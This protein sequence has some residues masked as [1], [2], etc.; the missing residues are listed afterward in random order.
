MIFIGTIYIAKY[1]FWFLK[2]KEDHGDHPE[3]QRDPPQE[4]LTERSESDQAQTCCHHD[5]LYLSIEA[6]HFDETAQSRTAPEFF[7]MLNSKMAT[8]LAHS[9]QGKSGLSKQFIWTVALAIDV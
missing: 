8:A 7:G 4:G 5:E 2:E 3:G 6:S 1:D 9:L